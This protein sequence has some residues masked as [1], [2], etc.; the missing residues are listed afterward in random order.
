MTLILPELSLQRNLV[1]QSDDW[2][3]TIVSALLRLA[4]LNP[5]AFKTVLG[6]IDGTRRTLLES[7]LRMTLEG[8]REVKIEEQA[9]PSISLTLD[10]ASIE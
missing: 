7:M 10:F 9:K 6:R 4:A 5:R 2:Q 8:R 1:T 3:D